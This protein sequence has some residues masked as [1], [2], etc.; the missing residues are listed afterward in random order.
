MAISASSHQ[1]SCR[2]YRLLQIPFDVAIVH[3]YSHTMSDSAA[4][5]QRSAVITKFGEDLV[6]KTQGSVKQPSTLKPG[7]CLIKLDYA[8]VCHS[9]IHAKKGDWLSQPTLPRVGGHEGVGHVVAIGE[10][11]LDPPVEVGDR[12]GLKWV[13][14][15]CL[16]CEMCRKG[17]EI[18][19]SSRW[20][21][22][23]ISR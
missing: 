12:V 7:E 11:S 1:T 19:T 4:W 9:D 16:K 13:A 2:I 10:H 23:N 20:L 15:A 6:L 21:W 3:A 17:F 5:T 8:G 14:T 18:R 22:M